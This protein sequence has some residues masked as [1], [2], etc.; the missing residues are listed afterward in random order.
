MEALKLQYYTYEEY[1]KWPEQPRYELIDGTP[2]LMAAPN[3]IHAEIT[4]NLFRCIDRYLRDKP[5]EPY[6]APMDVR[7]FADAFTNGDTVVQPD[8]FVVC[9]KNK[10]D[11][12]GVKGVPDFIIE[13]LSP[14]SGKMDKMIKFN[15]YEQAGVPE[16]WIVDPVHQI[17]TVYILNK[18]K[19]ARAVEYCHEDIILVNVIS[20]LK[21]DLR[22]IFPPQED[23]EE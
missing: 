12:K 13:I 18:G 17:V 9:D 7:L 11:K 6:F 2:Y 21:I 4:K 14:G 20:G 23:I 8:V 16:L 15:K 10:L 1:T 19:Y 3:R 5:C 22:E